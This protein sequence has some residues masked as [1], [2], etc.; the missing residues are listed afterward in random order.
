[1]LHAARGNKFVALFIGLVLQVLR[2]LFWERNSSLGYLGREGFY[3]QLVSV[4]IFSELESGV[5][6]CPPLFGP[7][8]AFLGPDCVEVLLL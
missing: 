4:A 7:L 8:L 2:F 6:P 1:M 3:W 5:R